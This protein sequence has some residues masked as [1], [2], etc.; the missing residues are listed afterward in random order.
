MSHRH[1]H[2]DYG[3]Y[4]RFYHHHPAPRTDFYNLP[5][6]HGHPMG[7]SS[8][9]RDHLPPYVFDERRFPDYLDP[10]RHAPP[11]FSA[12]YRHH[13]EHRPL[14]SSLYDLFHHRSPRRSYE[15][16]RPE[17]DD[18]LPHPVTWRHRDHPVPE[19]F[20]SDYLPADISI[21][22]LFDNLHLNPGQPQHTRAATESR[23]RPPTR[24]ATS[25]PALRYVFYRWTPET[26]AAPENAAVSV[27]N[28]L[29]IEVTIPQ[30]RPDHG[31]QDLS[32]GMCSENYRLD[33]NTAILPCRGLHRFHVDCI[34]PW[35]EQQ[36]TD[37]MTCPYCRDPFKVRPDGA[38]VRETA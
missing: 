6:L 3:G 19:A 22:S 16:V 18:R 32:C 30:V 35:F 27:P 20:A 37:D 5:S 9:T 33:D 1:F 4:G 2:G 10:E 24:L 21:E 17:H 8:N 38:I 28:D 36:G 31:D 15:R 29:N 12:D 34:N 14:P 7:S 23:S 26:I 13:D 11:S 25:G